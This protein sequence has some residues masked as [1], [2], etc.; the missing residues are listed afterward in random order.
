MY[1]LTDS[2][3]DARADKVEQILK[4]RGDM[5]EH[6]PHTL[7]LGPD[8]LIYIMLGNKTEPDRKVDAS[9]PYRNY[10]EADLLSPK[11]EDPRGHAVGIKAPGGQVLRT[12][13]EGSFLESYAGGMRNA[14][15]MAFDRQ[16]N[17]FTYDS[18]MEWDIGTPWYRPTRV[19]QL[20]SG[21]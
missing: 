14:Y 12:D 1:R 11:Y 9:S 10:Y 18:D 2:D 8:G 4:F 15:D 16:G 3:G 7:L 20:L 21:C 13:T 17:L 5:G 6:G 19:F